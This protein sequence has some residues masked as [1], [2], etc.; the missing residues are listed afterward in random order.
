MPILLA[1]LAV[2]VLA[3][4]WAL[5]VLDVPA[6]VPVLLDLCALVA[7][8]VGMTAR[9]LLARRKAQK[10]EQALG[11]AAAPAVDPLRSDR[12]A[13][14]ED[15]RR[16]FESGV[17]ALK[18]SR[19]AGGGQRAVRA[20]P[21]YLVLGAPNAGKTTLLRTSGLPFPSLGAARVP[22]GAP[23]R[24]PRASGARRAE[25]IMT[26]QAVLFDTAGAW[27][28]ENDG[29]VFSALVEL[30]ARHRAGRVLDGLVLTL[31]LEELLETHEAQRA[32]TSKRLRARI[33]ELLST[34]G[35]ALPVYVVVTKCDR[36]PGFVET[37]SGLARGERVA[38]WGFTL[39]LHAHAAGAIEMRLAELA[40]ALRRR[41]LARVAEE[42]RPEARAL[43]AEL[44]AHFDLLREPLTA[45]LNDLFAPNVYDE[46]PVLRGV[47][48]TSATQEASPIDALVARAGKTAELQARTLPAPSGEPKSYFVLELFTK[49]VFED[50]GLAAPS[51][52]TQRRRTF[53]EAAIGVALAGLGALV[54]ICAAF[55]W[56]QNRLL[57]DSTHALATLSIPASAAPIAPSALEPL[58]ARVDLLR[59]YGR[60]GPPLSMRMGLFPGARLTDHTS[61]RYAAAIRD[62][63]LVPLLRA[64]AAEL[65]SWGAT[66][67]AE[68]DREPTASEH[69]RALTLLERQLRFTSPRLPTEPALDAGGSAR[70]AR[71]LARGWCARLELEESECAPHASLFLAI[72][73]GGDA[74]R[75]TRDERA[76]RLG[77]LG[78]SRVPSGRV[79][80]E[81]LV[82]S[83][84]GRGY[85]VTLGRA[86][87]TTGRALVASAHVRGAFTRRG[88]EEIVR[89][90]I[91]GAIRDRTADAWLL[92]GA[93]D[94]TGDAVTRARRARDDL[95]AGYFAAYVDEWDAFLSSVRV[96]P[97]HDPSEALALLEDLT[98][99]TPPPIGRLL[100]AVEDNATLIDAAA[101]SPVASSAA[102]ELIDTIRGR[103]VGNGGASAAPDRAPSSADVVRR[104]LGAYT[105]FAVR[106]EGS[107]EDAPLGVDV[108]R[109]ELTLLRDALASYQ[110]DPSTGSALETRV[111][112]A[113]RRV[114][115]LVAEQPLGA[116]A[117]FETML[118]P[119][120][121][122]ASTTSSQAMASAVAAS[123]CASITAPFVASLAG[124]Y[125]FA[126]EGHDAALADFTAFYRPGSGTVWSFY[127]AS[128][129]AIAPRTGS[130]FAIEHRL[131]HGGR[132]PYGASLPAFL[133]RTST[134]TSAFFAPGASE[135]QVE[136]DLRVH[137]TAG[138]ASVRL[139]VGGA[140]IDYRN[141]PET[142]SRVVWP[143]SSPSAGASLE[144]LNARGMQERLR[145]TGEWG[146]FRLIEAATE[147]EPAPGE[148][149]H[150][151]RWHFPGHDVDVLIDVR[152]LRAESPFFGSDRRGRPLAPLRS[153]AVLAPRRIA[154][155]ARECVP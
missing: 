42:R 9:W 21:W 24:P 68:L 1:I 85:D 90:R 115:G 56:S 153:A 117:F 11:R 58:R 135:P 155:E 111:S 41:V 12:A 88:W 118:R 131:A 29:V 125:P 154:H 66:F 89:A 129:A 149:T 27:S 54:A 78:L 16:D 132:S 38:P 147:I 136:L 112:A 19:L 67:E 5:C 110:D 116:R 138:A 26:N 77:R 130:R 22:S 72:A 83:A 151:L 28:V 152:S 45:M 93:T 55:S 47:Y 146:L 122:A 62:G 95:R 119:P 98:R 17:H 39:P 100:V 63:V 113:R 51:T 87:G 37:F 76:V 142:W 23:P 46:T 150:T 34:A 44:P 103:V 35:L 53:I 33:D 141:G 143:G 57:V 59:T 106:D 3:L 123:F 128:L 13:E 49:I 81:D 121:E 91:D 64:E 108:Y 70:V 40:A 101:E 32:T 18:R 20:L 97:A 6:W 30:L 69:A 82:V 127:D 2:L 144:V 140:M 99:G 105:H 134:I 25:L 74:S 109:E 4:P 145:E 124:H 137:P 79:A 15:L 8:G 120:V 61:A 7:I 96:A 114:D 148:R 126:A 86:I 133:Q 104:A 71:A 94:Q 43:T 139:S 102:R 75:V 65:S 80:L 31:S 14:I 52:R 10:L 84:E 50:A 48:F 73:H 36:L 107:P 92:G 60:E